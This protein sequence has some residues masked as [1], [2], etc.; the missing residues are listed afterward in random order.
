MRIRA[1]GALRRSRDGLPVSAGG[2]AGLERLD[3]P[4]LTPQTLIRPAGLSKGEP[5]AL[6][7]C[8]LLFFAV[9]RDRCDCAE[10]I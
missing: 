10:G 2:G 7:A 6:G 8:R 9:S 1:P 4:L 3:A 5:W